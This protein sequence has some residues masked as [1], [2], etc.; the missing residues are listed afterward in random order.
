M[1][2]DMRDNIAEMCIADR[3]RAAERLRVRNLSERKIEWLSFRQVASA[4]CHQ[5]RSF[6]TACRMF[7]QLLFKAAQ[8][9]PRI[10][11]GVMT[12][13]ESDAN[14]VVADKFGPVSGQRA[15]RRG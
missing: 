2:F 5:R 15:I 12:I 6:V 13:G 8:V 4:R 9:R 7:G 3:D 10:D 1:L 14:G 11:A